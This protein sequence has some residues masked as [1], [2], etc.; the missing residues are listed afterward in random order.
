MALGKAAA[1]KMLALR[2]NDRMSEKASYAPKSGPGVFQLPA[3]ANPIGPHWG[4]GYAVRAQE[5]TRTSASR[6]RHR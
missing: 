1:E 5:H 3:N 2:R 6:A 4:V